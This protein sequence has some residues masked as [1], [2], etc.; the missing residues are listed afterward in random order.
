MKKIF[1][2]IGAAM[3]AAMA[4]NGEVL[5]NDSFAYSPG[6]LT[7]QG[8]WV[9]SGST[10]TYPINVT[11]G[12]LTRD[13]YQPDAS[14]NCVKISMDMGKSALQ[15][16]FAPVGG[17]ALSGPVYYSAL[18]RV[19]DFPASL[20]KPGAIIS[21]TGKNSYSGEMGD[22]I[23]GSEGG[24]LFVKKG[25]ADG[26]AVFGIS[27]AS[28][29]NGVTA[30]YVVWD[31]TDI[32]VGETALVVVC[33]SSGDGT[34][35]DTMELYVNP[36]DASATA[37]VTIGANNTV[38]ETLCD[39]RG[40][41]LCQRSALTSKSPL[42]TVD[43]LR[44]ATDL[45][46]I[47]SGTTAPVKVPNVTLSENPVDF[48]QVYCN[49]PVSRTL[50]V[51][52]TDLEDDIT[53][54][55][56]ES[57][58][59]ELSAATIA[60]EAAMAEGGAE[61]TVTLSAVESRFF[62]ERIT[63]ST[64]G[65]AD[66]VLHI[67]WHPVPTFV[68]STFSQLCDED[69]NDMSSVYV[70]NGEATVTFIESYYDLSYD[71]VVNSIFAQDATGGVELRSAS[72][73]GYQE[74]DITG[75]KV[76]DN[77]TNIVGYLI[78]G[79]SGLTMIPR[80]AADWEVVSEGNS[81]EPIELTLRQIAM[82][83]NGYVYGNQLVRVKN[84]TF[85]D[86]YFEAGDYHGLWNS[87]KYQIFDGTLDDYDGVAWMWCN[88]GADYFKTSTEG[89]FDHRW[90]LTGIV[91]NYYPIHISPRSKADFEDE[92]LK[93]S[94]IHEAGADTAGVHVTGAFDASG[95]RVDADTARG[96]VILRMSD[97]SARKV[98]R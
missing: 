77:I 34:A 59:I 69:V 79:D 54:T 44:V 11:E 17:D 52:A 72:G 70:Y 28:S 76:G 35:D 89:Y 23:T 10:G 81:V 78:F 55:L 14:G 46:G 97:G 8:T 9:M 96:V 74:I 48:G 56:G 65:M 3:C 1:T 75:V 57:G 67:D 39:V 68:A 95:R 37:D 42:C 40:I 83:E 30:T 27:R 71:R 20:G 80:T 38:D 47:F 21:L 51:M 41:Q 88:K 62:S 85:P 19:D 93:Y 87:Q 29:P 26:T 58:Q 2:L 91:N 12:S 18:V 63:I 64:P 82:A 73:C 33:Y 4:A 50:R 60:R 49:V 43:E 24:G 61:L 32:P 86:E 45:E 90:T 15:S 66:K 25:S 22:A 36:A 92:G 53:L 16:I 7:S 5:L 94:G 98:V 6:A 31:D 13:G 84:V